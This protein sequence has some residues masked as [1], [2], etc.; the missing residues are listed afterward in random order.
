MAG[1]SQI[2]GIAG[3]VSVPYV[4][5]NSGAADS[6]DKMGSMIE[7]LTQMK[8]A[9]QA[10]AGEKFGRMMDAMEKWGL[11][12]DEGALRKTAKEA[13]MPLAKEQDLAAYGKVRNAKMEGG[14]GKGI[15]GVDP[16]HDGGAQGP[17]TNLPGG[18][19]AIPKTDTSA[20]STI[21]EAMNPEQ[22]KK[23]MFGQLVQQVQA[24]GSSRIKD[25]V[26]L[27]QFKEQVDVLKNKYMQTGSMEAIGK[28]AALGEIK[29]D[30]AYEQWS[31]MSEKQRQDTLDM[32]AGHESDKD[33][34]AR[35]E[36]VGEALFT[37]GKFTD[38][39]LA[40]KAGDAIAHGGDIPAELR[41]QMKPF[42]FK[43][44][45]DQGAM[46]DSLIKLGVKPTDVGQVAR[47]AQMVGL[48]NALPKGITPI[49]LQEL[50][51]QKKQVD[52]EATRADTENKRLGVEDKRYQAELAKV[53]IA[54]QKEEHKQT[55]DDMKSIIDMKKAGV[56][57]PQEIWDAKVRSFADATGLDVKEVPSF[58]K[59][60][61]GG[62]VG[63]DNTEFTPRAGDVSK[64][65]GKQQGHRN[66]DDESES[67]SDV[68][69]DKLREVMGAKKKKKSDDEG[70]M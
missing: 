44:I 36:R 63:G 47:N 28:L 59:R 14:T 23:T 70:I 6:I 46:V 26:Q 51:L 67:L 61:T 31:K 22:Q 66:K 27:A 69:V 39:A 37:S 18:A 40:Y 57:I 54:E 30:L 3:T 48:E 20:M 8:A 4:D 7:R 42:T 64:F 45:S 25:A 56:K 62:L 11:P 10:A 58:I 29:P 43:E 19:Q 24:I 15:P 68:M 33:K 12:L 41:A 35:G 65:S 13:G 17:R 9:K 52:I 55:V 53:V 21:K 2:S 5:A 49:A 34:A 60:L 1:P 32:M 16:N 38:P 50:A